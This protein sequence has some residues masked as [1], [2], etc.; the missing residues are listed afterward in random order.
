MKRR[1]TLAA[2]LVP[3]L[4]VALGGCTSDASAGRVELTFLSVAFQ[5]ATVEAT[6]D[7]IQSWNEAHP[8]IQVTVLQSNYDDVHD[9]LVTQFQSNT[10]ADLIY[11]EASDLAGFAHQGYLADLSPL[12]SEELREDIPEKY[13]DIVTID[14]RVIAAPTL[15]Q[16]YVV[17]ANTKLLSEA[18]VAMPSETSLSWSSLRELASSLTTES[19]YGVG[20]GLRQ[21]ASAMMNTALNYGGT[22]FDVDSDGSA[23]IEVDDAELAVPDQV[24]GMLFEDGSMDPTSV[25]QSTAEVVPGF[26]AGDY[27][28]F[29]GASYLAQQLTE[30]APE[31]FSFS[32]LPPLA[33]DR[34]AAQAANP[35][36]L[37]I[38]AQSPHQAE[39]AEFLEY[40]MA[41]EHISRLGQSDWLRPV[42]TSALEHLEQATAEIPVWRPLLETGADLVGAP[43]TRALDYPQWKLQYATPGLQKYFA[44]SLSREELAAFWS[45]GWASIS[46]Q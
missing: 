30:G 25:T 2:V 26:F 38:A 16:S 8:D 24:H 44:G 46:D 4:A 20:W 36:T 18:G 37:S 21:P 35:Q 40:F 17:F 32:V 41:A 10:P 9:Q 23:T 28:M 12:L 31:G 34:G 42:P 22:F 11:N 15:V 27:A 45:D 19:R 3:A 6:D 43:F 29:I 14:D 1:S 13:W 39:A 7:I 5:D 33:G